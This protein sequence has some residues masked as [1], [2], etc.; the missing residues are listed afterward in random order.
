MQMRC[1]YCQTMFAISRDEMLAALQHMD[2]NNLKY[3]DAHCPKCRRANRV[4]GKRIAM[5][6]PDWK[7]TIRDME[8]QATGQV[9]AA[10]APVVKAA[11][12]VKTG[13]SKAGG[14][15]TAAK[16]A[17]AA[18]TATKAKPAASKAAQAKAASGKPAAKK[19]TPAK[20]AAKKPATSKPAVKKPAP[21]KTSAN[22][23]ASTKTTAKKPAPAKAAAKKSGSKASGTTKK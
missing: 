17:P 9:K 4:E 13:V 10:E 15:V 16:K 20:T 18:K 22:K 14:K 2:Q 19:A 3:Y 7:K 1:S 23:P 11:D 5:F 12:V 6:F 8:R 21:Q